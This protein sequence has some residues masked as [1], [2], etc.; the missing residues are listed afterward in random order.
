MNAMRVGF[1]LSMVGDAGEFVGRLMLCGG[2]GFL[3]RRRDVGGG[4]EFVGDGVLAVAARGG[5]GDAFDEVGHCHFDVEFDE[6]GEGV[7][8]D[9][10]ALVRRHIELDGSVELTRKSLV[11]TSRQLS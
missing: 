6:V 11:W 2:A 4:F 7:E 9:I 1:A 5:D 10:S 3:A 8:L